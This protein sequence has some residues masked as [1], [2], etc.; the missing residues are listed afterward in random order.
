MIVP[1]SDRA[2]KWGYVIWPKALDDEIHALL[3]DAA[4]VSV[5]FEGKNAG[6]KR[7][8]WHRRRISVGPAQTRGLPA[9]ITGFVL[10]FRKPVLTIS[11]R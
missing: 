2:R 9:S 4:T 1:I 6:S 8:D 10:E 11:C 5:S 7:V 3:G